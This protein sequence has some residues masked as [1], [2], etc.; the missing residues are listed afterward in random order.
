[1]PEY[2]HRT[3]I[4][5]DKTRLE[6]EDLMR[7]RGAD[8]FFSGADADCAVLAFRLKGRHLRFTVPL[9]AISDQMRRSRWRQLLLVIKAKLAAIDVGILAWDE[10]FLSDTILPNRKTVAEVMLP[11]IDAAYKT[12]EMPPLLGYQPGGHDDS[13]P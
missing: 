4:A 10:A 7:R 8:Q 12:G 13:A 2:A 5:A 3:K 6:I 9:G 11:Q 1:V